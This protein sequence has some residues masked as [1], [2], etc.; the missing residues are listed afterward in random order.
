M[1]SYNDTRILEAFMSHLATAS[2]GGVPIAWPN[3]NYEPTTGT[4]F[5]KADW[6]PAQTTTAT[7]GPTGV[8][9][10]RGIFQ[11]QAY[12]EVGKGSVAAME[13][14]GQVATRF[15]KG[16]SMTRDG[17]T[18]LIDSPPYPAPRIIEGAWAIYTLTIPY[19]SDNI[20][21]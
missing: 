14:L 6:L 2:L 11:V 15:A 17:V 4:T 18:V 19:Q 5:L 8:N 20:T 16:T 9:R 3:V 10:H 12:V 13:L 7:L 21:P 1:A